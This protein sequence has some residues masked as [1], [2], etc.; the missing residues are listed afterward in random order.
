MDQHLG[1]PH[2]TAKEAP[3]WIARARTLA[4]VIEAAAARN[5]KDRR[6]DVEWHARE[7]LQLF[8]GQFLSCVGASRTQISR[9]C[10]T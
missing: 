4:P 3:D 6:I 2:R 1:K 9:V 10:P 7:R 8:P 5:E